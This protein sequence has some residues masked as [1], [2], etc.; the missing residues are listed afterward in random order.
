MLI[1]VA[2]TKFSGAAASLIITDAP[3]KFGGRGRPGADVVLVP[4]KVP[5]IVIS[6]PGATGALA[7]LAPFST[8]TK[9]GA[10][11]KPVK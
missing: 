5:K 1:C 7:K 8:L 2:F 3:P 11:P 9:V 10:G 6:D 4:G